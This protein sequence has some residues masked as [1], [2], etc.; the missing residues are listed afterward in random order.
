MPKINRGQPG[1]KIHPKGILKEWP[2][3]HCYSDG[4]G[5]LWTHTG[6]GAEC[7]RPECVALREPVPWGYS[8]EG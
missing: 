2:P 7:Q 4:K 1:R 3:S 8:D 6:T 5:G